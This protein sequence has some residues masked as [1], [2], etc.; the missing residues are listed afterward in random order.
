[1]ENLVH[2]VGLQLGERSVEALIP[3]ASRVGKKLP[4]IPTMYEVLVGMSKGIRLQLNIFTK[5][6]SN[7]ALMGFSLL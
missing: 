4:G 3:E 5:F 1:M 7:Y 2:S 6:P